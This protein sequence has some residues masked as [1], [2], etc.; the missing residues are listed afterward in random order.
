[1]VRPITGEIFIDAPVEEVFDFVA[2]EGNEPLYNPNML[3]AGKL[4]PG[5][6][7]AGTR[8]AAVMR[9]RRRT[10]LA[11]EYTGFN[12]PRTLRSRSRTAGMEI[13]GEL[14]FVPEGNGTWL[15]W[16]WRVHPQGA[17]RLLTPLI[18][19]MRNRQERAHWSALKGYLESAR[20]TA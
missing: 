13:E 2:D 3:R 4:T 15:R 11:I 5:P 10:T 20:R 19:A 7:G 14:T 12:R 16:V 8:F 17:L 9:G 18:R 6:V 1:M